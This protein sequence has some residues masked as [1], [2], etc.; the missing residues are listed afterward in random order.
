MRRFELLDERRDASAQRSSFGGLAPRIVLAERFLDLSNRLEQG[1]TIFRLEL[2]AG[3]ELPMKC[4]Q[5]AVQLLA[6]HTRDTARFR[7]AREEA[8]CYRRSMDGYPVQLEIR[9][10]WGDM[11][12]LGHVNNTIYLRWFESAR[13]AFFERI[14]LSASRPE[15]VGPIL[16]STTCDYLTPV[17]YPATVLVGARLQ[18]IGNTSFVIE[19]LATKD[20]TPVARGTAIV[21]LIDYETG[22]KVPVPDEIRASIASLSG[23]QAKGPG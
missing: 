22:A 10:A 14:A 19:H 21:V 12:A 5:G 16:A 20:G 2:G 8:R 9:V 4:D 11:D 3:L 17:V 18:R 6:W 7:P 1:L 15:K 23:G 13:I